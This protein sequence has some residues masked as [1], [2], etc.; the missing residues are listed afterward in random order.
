[1][2]AAGEAATA[3]APADAA[4]GPSVTGADGLAVHVAG[5][6]RHPGLV[7]LPAGSRVADALAAAGGPVAGADLDRINLA[8]KLADGEQVLV[9]RRGEAAPPPAAGA[10]ADPG[11]PGVPAAKIDLNTASVEQL[12]ALPGVGAVTAG[13]IVAFRARRPFRSVQDLLQ[14]EGIGERR[15]ESLRDLVTVG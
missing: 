6:V 12:E 9:L 3:D 11:A 4:A 2:P 13:R 14:V 15:L 1:V 7:S 10:P 8:R 5:R